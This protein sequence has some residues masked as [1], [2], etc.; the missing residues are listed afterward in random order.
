[1]H[2]KLFILI[3]SA[4]DVNIFI[5]RIYFI[6]IIFINCKPPHHKG[7]RSISGGA[8]GQ[9]EGEREQHIFINER[10]CKRLTLW[11]FKKMPISGPAC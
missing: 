8:P 10:T 3:F 11:H 9:S 2:L 1:M 5:V 4:N 7:G 6:D